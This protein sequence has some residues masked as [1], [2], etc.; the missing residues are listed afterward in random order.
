MFKSRSLEFVSVL[1]LIFLFFF[2]L[3]MITFIPILTKLPYIKTG[4]KCLKGLVKFKSLQ[5]FSNAFLKIN[6]ILSVGQLYTELPILCCVNK[7]RD[8][9]LYTLVQYTSKCSSS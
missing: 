3:K 6:Q 2:L 7:A 4:I 1:K 9:L 8:M 5:S